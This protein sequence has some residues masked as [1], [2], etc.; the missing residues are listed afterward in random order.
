MEASGSFFQIES[1]RKIERW[2]IVGGIALLT[3]LLVWF[4]AQGDAAR[5][6]D[7][8]MRILW[9]LI[10]ATFAGLVLLAGCIILFKKRAGIVLLH[11]GIGLMMLSELMVGTMAV[12]TQMMV[13]EG[14]TINYV[15]DVR[16]VE[17]AIIDKTNPKHDQVTVIPKSI[18]LAKQQQVVSDP[19]L[20][21]DYE[22]VEYYQNSSLRRVSSLTPE[23]KKTCQESGDSRRGQGVDCHTST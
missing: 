17:I 19:K 11:G 16:E 15:Q 1:F 10:K 5:F 6:S 9:Q 13:T 7:S 4:L 22:L 23:E 2:L 20:P 21:F 3:C 14:Q 8:S 18:L 12:E